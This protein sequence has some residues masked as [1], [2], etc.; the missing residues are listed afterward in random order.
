MAKKEYI[1]RKALLN[2]L[3]EIPALKDNPH[4][5]ELCK[6]WANSVP[7]ADVV[8]REYIEEKL[9]YLKSRCKKNVVKDFDK[10]M[11]GRLKIVSIEDRIIDNKVCENEKNKW[12]GLTM[13][14]KEYIE[15]NKIIDRIQELKDNLRNKIF[16]MTQVIVPYESVFRMVGECFAISNCE[17]IILTIPTAD[18]RENVRGYWV[19]QYDDEGYKL[20]KRCTICSESYVMPDGDLYFCP[21]C[22]ADMRGE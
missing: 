3:S 22:G 9:N 15:R 1:E 18:V 20:G 17:N 6:E 14:E 2:K 12:G 11:Y 8:P 16:G 10:G 7:V 13:P 5:M 19:Q 4:L 21:N